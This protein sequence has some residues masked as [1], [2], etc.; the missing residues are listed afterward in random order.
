[1]VTL[2]K[3]FD[4][5]AC[6]ILLLFPHLLR[7][8]KE[9]GGSYRLI[10]KGNHDSLQKIPGMV[11]RQNKCSLTMMSICSLFLYTPCPGRDVGQSPNLY[12]HTEGHLVIVTTVELGCTSNSGRTGEEVRIGCKSQPDLCFTAHQLLVQ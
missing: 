8:R 6:P 5:S 10:K 2:G 4:L 9:V 7:V 3:L 11:S 1:M 12:L